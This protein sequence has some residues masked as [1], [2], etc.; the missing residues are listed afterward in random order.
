MNLG[1]SRRR[2]ILAIGVLLVATVVITG[3]SGIDYM[4]AGGR[5]LSVHA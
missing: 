2:V 1:G 4:V 5:K 3:L